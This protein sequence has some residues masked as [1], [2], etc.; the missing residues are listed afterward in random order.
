MHIFMEKGLK[1]K[2]LISEVLFYPPS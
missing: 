1:E 2:A